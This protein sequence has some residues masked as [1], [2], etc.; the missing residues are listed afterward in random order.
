V[1][2]VARSLTQ[3]ML[4]NIDEIGRYAVFLDLDGTIAEIA[5]HPDAVHIPQP[6]LRLLASICD[7]TNHALAVISGRD[8]HGIDRLLNPLKLPVAGVHGLQRRDADGVMHAKDTPAI[9]P[10]VLS[11]EEAI[12][13]EPGIVIEQKP[14]AVALHY[15]LRPDL[16][17]RCCA[18]VKEIVDRRSDFRLISG[19]MVFEIVPKGGDKGQVIETFLGELPFYGRRPLFAG[20]D[21]TDETGFRVMNALGGVSIKIGDG[22]TAAR[23]RAVNVR[24]FRN[25]LCALVNED[26]RKA[27]N[28]R[29]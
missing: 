18:I 22:E 29:S 28:E 12:G 3:V 10:V 27:C 15:R 20:D 23:F 19:K 2:V 8:I 16:E 24:Q 25:W 4:P 7:R 17:R 13:K 1:A 26:P 5:D 9:R 6:T 21:V 14:G 11:L